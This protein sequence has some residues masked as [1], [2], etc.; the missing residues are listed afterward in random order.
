MQY[1]LSALRSEKLPFDVY[2][3]VGR[4][5]VA[6]M[7]AALLHAS[8]YGKKGMSVLMHDYRERPEYHV[9]QDFVDIIEHSPSWN[10][11]LF[12][13]KTHTTDE[14]IFAFQ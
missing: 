7:C 1:Q 3:E 10:L 13:R 4:Y 12:K 6:S 8:K 5:R 2:L 9:V 11:V 14:H